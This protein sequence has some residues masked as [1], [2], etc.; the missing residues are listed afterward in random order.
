MNYG[1][2]KSAVRDYVHRAD[3]KTQANEA[4]AVQLAQAVLGRSFYPR[5][6]YVYVPSIPIVNGL[7]DLPADFS[8]ADSVGSSIGQLEWISTREYDSRKLSG[9]YG[10]AYA[11]SGK[12]IL[13]DP[14][15][16]EISL[17][18]YAVPAA[19]SVDSDTS[20][21]SESYPDVLLWMAVAE[22]H[23]FIEDFE[24]AAIATQHAAALAQSASDW[25]R[26]G[27]GSGGKLRMKGR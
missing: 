25:S 16:V 20:W 12:L 19:L 24:A 11:L 27:E 2:I 8:Q 14:A 21:L 17:G 26:R 18:Y 4:R 13:V 3:Q 7:G 9:D 22:Q 6:A 1:E 10:A 5:E 23:R 15:L